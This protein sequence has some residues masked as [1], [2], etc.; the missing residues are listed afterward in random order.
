M[1]PTTATFPELALDA[2]PSQH[3]RRWSDGLVPS[4][5]GAD[6]AGAWSMAQQWPALVATLSEQ[7][8]DSSNLVLRAMDFL[9][10]AGRLR[11]AE[12]KILVD[13]LERMRETSLRAQQI[14]RLSTGRIRHTR[15][16]VELGSVVRELLDG[17]REEFDARNVEVAAELAPVDVL[18]DPPV[19]VTI[20]NTVI[21]WALSFSV[22]V[23]IT[24]DT[25][26]W[27]EPARLIARVATPS[28]DA[29]PPAAA[30]LGAAWGGR[31]RGR[32]VNDGLHWMLLRQM[33][34]SANLAVTRT[35]GAGVALL[36]I[37]FPK[38]FNSNGGLSSLEMFEDDASGAP[39]LL[40][41]WVL[42]AISDPSLRQAAMQALKL[43]G[44]S[45]KAACDLT[46]AR[47]CVTGTRPDAIVVSSDLVSP[48]FSRF[49]AETAGDGRSC[50]IV[51]I[52]ERQPSF[53]ASGFEGFEVA[54]IGRDHLRKELAP[55]VLFE[56]VKAA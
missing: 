41:A 16:R 10:G 1:T 45:A 42:V 53:N 17:R 5:P 56:L 31:G 21:D 12:A 13:A 38:T 28:A 35:G 55:T 37:E 44:I 9:V 19:V 11:R 48:E 18:L 47:A 29:Q 36:T 40:N 15:D 2:A 50:P 20:V 27:P 6:S 30:P 34:H 7:C 25:P 33:A 24:L 3:Q 23:E 26:V 46:D 32:R 8:M 39:S 49:R 43:A 4:T 52:T 54:K 51:E 22:K 14:T